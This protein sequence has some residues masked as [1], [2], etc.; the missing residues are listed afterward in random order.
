MKIRNASLNQKS[1]KKVNFSM[2]LVFLAYYDSM[3]FMYSFINCL[4]VSASFLFTSIMLLLYGDPDAQPAEMLWF[5]MFFVIKAMPFSSRMV[6][7]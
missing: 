7:M 5:R 1:L 4:A 6:E 2:K 3:P